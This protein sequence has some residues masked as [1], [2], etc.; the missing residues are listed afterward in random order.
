MRKLLVLILVLLVPLVLAPGG[1]PLLPPHLERPAGSERMHGDLAAVATGSAHGEAVEARSLVPIEVFPIAGFDPTSLLVSLGATQILQIGTVVTAKIP[2]SSLMAL[3]E[4]DRLGWIQPATRPTPTAIVGE[5][6][7]FIDADDYHLGGITGSGVAVAVIDT[8]FLGYQTRVAEGDLPGGMVLENHCDAGFEAGG[9]HGTAS[10]EIVHEVAPGA[11]LH[12]V[13]IDDLGDLSSAVG[14]AAAQGVD[15]I[16]MSLA[17]SNV[18]RGDG[19]GL[20]AP[21]IQTARDNGILWVNSAGN[22]ADL[23]WSGSFSD[24][25]GDDYHDFV[26]L[27]D[28]TNAVL[29]APGG[30]LDAYLKWDDWPVTST[31]YDLYLF[32]DDF[33]LLAFSWNTQN[34]TQPPTEALSFTNP[35]GTPLIL[36]LAI[37]KWSASSTPR[38]DLFVYGDAYLQHV[39]PA[40]SIADPA[41]SSLVTAVGA[42]DVS[43]GSIEDFSS[44]GP[45]IDGRL[46]PDLTG[47]DRVSSASYGTFSG[48]SASAP[49]VAG[50]AALLAES[51]G[52]TD[53]ATVH[54]ALVSLTEDR[55]DVG[56]DHVYG[57]GLLRL[58]SPP[59]SPPDDPPSEVIRYA[60]SNR[61]ATAAAVAAAEFP[62]PALVTRV[63]IAAGHNFPD[64][65]AGAAVAGALGS[66]LLLVERDSIPGATAA[67]LARLDPDQVVVLGGEAVISPLVADALAAFGTVHRLAGAN[68]YTTAVEISK[69]GFPDPQTVDEVIVAT[70]INFPDALGGGPVGVAVGG[71]VL[72]VPTDSLPGAVR[73]EIARLDP[74]RITVLGGSAAVSDAVLAQLQTLAPTSRVAASN[75]YKTAVEASKHGFPGT[76]AFVYLAVG[77][78]FPDALAGSAAAGA[79]GA[80][81]LLTPASSLPSEVAAEILRLGATRVIILGGT[82][83][84]TSAVEDQVA[85]LIT[86]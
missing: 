6:I 55:G 29:L 10:A 61:Y 86:P 76:S 7:A 11:T 15:V 23:H 56:W 13:C 33:T 82:G 84:I 20:L 24:P 45:T 44:R 78:N 37:G 52:T 81:V 31:D 71:P 68:R 42:A 60:G 67:E 77:T 43:T 51:L 28:E 53:P 19:S 54:T 14:S 26:P 50:A 73:D 18:G 2:P 48:T 35:T 57:T 63:F 75:R 64:A 40:G 22:F 5:G 34:G 79:R 39:V 62:D 70:G 4:D 32:A 69:F 9:K 47:P 80:P 74:S 58:G 85:A 27:L 38:M 17:W 72:L 36:H 8:G 66:P 30:R 12:L 46:K 21:I 41:T 25:D 1:K 65:L 83:A 3:A 16:S 49:H 59:G